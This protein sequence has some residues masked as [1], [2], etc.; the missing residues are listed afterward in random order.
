MKQKLIIVIAVLI[1]TVNCSSCI[2]REPRGRGTYYQRHH[3]DH[4]HLH[5]GTGG[6]MI[7]R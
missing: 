4:G 2:V 5:H 6:R 3:G 1:A 7:I